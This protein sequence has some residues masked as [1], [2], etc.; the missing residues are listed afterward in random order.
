MIWASEHG[1]DAGES[2]AR[3]TADDTGPQPRKEKNEKK[4]KRV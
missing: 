4:K 2:T 1:H 3:K